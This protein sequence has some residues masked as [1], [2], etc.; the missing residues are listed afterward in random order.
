M[1]ETSNRRP[2]CA[3]KTASA[4]KRETRLRPGVADSGGQAGVGRPETGNRSPVTDVRWLAIGLVALFGCGLFEPRNPEP[5]GQTSLDYIPATV[6]GI[7][8]SNL[9]NAIAQKNVDNYVRSFSDPAVSSVT[10]VFNPSADASSIYPNVR[11]WTFADEREYFQ[12]L[13]AKADGF[14]SLILTPKD[15]LIGGTEAT[16]NFDYLLSFQHTDAAT[17]PTT[18]RGNLQFILAP[19]E[20]NIWSIFSWSDF[21]TSAEI[22][23]SSFKGKFGN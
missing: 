20:A 13:V 17:F 22:T 9:K 4:G 16:Y 14:S 6:P 1:R 3:R 19:D 5:P 10:F 23:W 2:A 21:S 7:V 8:M 18:A 15:S 12:N 11:E